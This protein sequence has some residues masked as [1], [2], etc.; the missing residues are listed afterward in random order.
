MKAF[1]LIFKD[2][3]AITLCYPNPIR[4]SSV[5]R[6]KLDADFSGRA[7]SG[8]KIKSSSDGMNGVLPPPRHGRVDNHRHVGSPLRALRTHKI[9]PRRNI[10]TSQ[11]HVGIKV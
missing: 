3:L 7:I 4:I 11:S 9:Y 8:Y 5:K 2:D 6:R 1:K 10:L